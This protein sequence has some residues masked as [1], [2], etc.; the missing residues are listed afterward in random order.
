MRKA[1]CDRCDDE[2]RP[3]NLVEVRVPNGSIANSATTVELCRRCLI[4]LR[5]FVSPL[6]RA[7]I[8]PSAA[9][10]QEP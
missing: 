7:G 8:A 4:K 10:S 3:E 2:T 6:P 1:F 9:P 5:E